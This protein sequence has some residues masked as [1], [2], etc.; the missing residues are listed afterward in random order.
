[1]QKDQIATSESCFL[2]QKL[3]VIQFCLWINF[4]CQLDH[5]QKYIVYISVFLEVLFHANL[6]L[7]NNRIQYEHLFPKN[8]RSWTD[9]VIAEI[10]RAKIKTY[11][12]KSSLYST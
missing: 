2:G 12:A 5:S 7:L 8:W 1:M 11:F 9:E 4:F 3:F 10:F 6:G